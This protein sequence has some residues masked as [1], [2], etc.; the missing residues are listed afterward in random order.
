MQTYECYCNDSGVLG[1]SVGMIGMLQ[2]NEVLK[3]VL[4]IGEILSGKLLVYN[5]L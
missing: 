4:G 3:M 5:M 1:I 2:A